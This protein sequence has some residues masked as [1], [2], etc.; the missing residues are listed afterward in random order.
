MGKPLEGIKVLELSTYVAGPTTARQLADMGAEVI[1]VETL[2]GDQWREMGR[3]LLHTDDM[4]N[5]FFDVYNTGKKCIS[6]NIKTQDGMELF[7]KLLAKADI[8][9]TNT[10]LKSLKKLGLDGE[11][12]LKKY[13]RLIFAGIDGF[14]T[15]GPD[16]ESAGFDNI[17]FWARS[18]FSADIPFK[19]E[20]S[21]PLPA[22]SGIGDCVTGGFLLA[23]VLAALYNRERTGKG[24]IVNASLYGTAIWCM[25]SMLLRADPS[26]GNHYPCSP[27]QADP[28]TYN[29]KCKDGEW[30]NISVR[31]YDNDAPKIYSILGIE[32]DVKALGDVNEKTYYLMAEKLI[33]VIQSGFIKMTYDEVAEKF[34]AADLAFGKLSHIED[35]LTDEQAWAN[36]FV[37]KTQNRNGTQSTIAC[38]PIRFASFEKEN[39]MPAPLL[40]E[41]TDE[42]MKD[43]GYTQEQI[44]RFKEE[45]AVK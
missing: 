5:P 9:V 35:I 10:R 12:L 24:D 28:L 19:T 44:D 39:S 7:H 23:G 42:I 40:G 2:I 43:C 14:G 26:Y 29:Y 15:K 13:P 3:K 1:K 34:K 20:D 37:E 11:T 31:I 6:I 16:A 38:P 4:E 17:S 18:G 33:P 36:S 30:C 21:Y 27:Y 45:G 22:T 25:S 41:N 8:F 32:D